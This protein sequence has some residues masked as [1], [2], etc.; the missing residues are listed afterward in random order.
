MC[1]PEMRVS[2]SLAARISSA[3]PSEDEIKSSSAI[4]S[5]DEIKSSSAI[6]SEDEIKSS[7]AI[8]SE[9]D[10]INIYMVKLSNHER[11]TLPIP[12]KILVHLTSEQLSKYEPPINTHVKII[13]DGEPSIVRSILQTP[14]GLKLQKNPL[15][16][17][18]IQ[19]KTK[20]NS[21]QRSCSE[22][23]RQRGRSYQQMLVAAVSEEKNERLKQ[24]FTK[25]F[26]IDV[27]LRRRRLVL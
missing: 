14:A 11:I 10:F 27:S 6:P 21:E 4:P 17:I 1:G 12:S 22:Q 9:D 23:S 2:G 5:E 25:I 13:V 7:S 19:N 20:N 8:P 15:I 26:N 16:K 24:K 18:S 3:I